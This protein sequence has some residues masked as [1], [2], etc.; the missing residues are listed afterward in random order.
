MTIPDSLKKQVGGEHYKKYKVQPLEF[1]EHLALTP[2]VFC[3]FKYVCRYKDKG[4]PIQDLKKALH[5]VDVFVE[6]GKEKSLCISI[7]KLNDFVCQFDEKQSE[8]LTKVIFLQGEK[9]KANEVKLA[10]YSLLEDCIDE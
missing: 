2:I 6:C 1:A 5:C 7:Q 3:I 8:A 10:I 9:S 4:K